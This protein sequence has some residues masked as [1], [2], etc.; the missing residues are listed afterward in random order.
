MLI[1][2]GRIATFGQNPQVI[3]DG[4]ICLADDQII[5]V[6]PTAELRARY[7]EA[8]QLDAKG[9]LIMPDRFARTRTST[10]RSPAAWRSPRAREELPRDSAETVVAARSGIG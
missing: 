7:P 5:A 10:A 2:H 6:G 4:A 3:E 1:I 9:Q 8:E